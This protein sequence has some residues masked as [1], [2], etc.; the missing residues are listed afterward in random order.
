MIIQADALTVLRTMPE[1]SV[2]CVVTSPPYWGLRDYRVPEQIG[3]ERTPAEYVEKLVSVFCEVRRV[4]RGDG[5]CWLNIGDSYCSSPRGNRPGDY[6]TSSLTNPERQDRVAR[7][8]RGKDCDPKRGPA[9]I[10]HPFHHATG[11]KPKDLVGIPWRV[12]FALQA[13]GWWLRQDI[14]WSKPNP[15][16]E[17]VRDRCTK[18]HEY[19][20]MLTKSAR[21]WYNA[22][23]IAEPAQLARKCGTNSRADNDRDPTHGTRKQDAVGNRRYAGFNERYKTNGKWSGEDP[24]SSG[25]RIVENVKRARAEGADHE[26]PWGPTRNKRS[27]WTVATQPYPEA[28]FATFPEKLVEPCILAG[29]PAGG[30]V[31]DPFCGSGTVGVVCK[32]HGREFLGIELNP[33]YIEM[34]ERR[35]SGIQG[36][37]CP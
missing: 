12:A 5:T 28:H 24:Q 36:V 26:A 17:G 9:A 4:L 7:G 32:R 31:L 11:L 2:H 22:A 37:L 27:V 21:Y 19:I 3:L 6:S 30:T 8:R 14:I 15:M 16:P 34:A 23:A 18:S 25:R 35:M 10:G 29:C 13:D 33:A 20:F 1:Q